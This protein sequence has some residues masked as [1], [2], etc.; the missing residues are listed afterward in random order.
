MRRLV[1]FASLVLSGLYGLGSAWADDDKAGLAFFESKIRPVL[2]K[3]CYE[4]HAKDAK[5]VGGKLLLDTRDDL[6]RGGESGS[7]MV[8]GKPGDSLLIHALRWQNDLEM[9]P[10]VPLTEA[11]IADFE[12][13]VAMGAPDP[14][15][16]E[17]AVPVAPHVPTETTH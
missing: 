1:P 16:P 12:K 7:P 9:P 2:V 3:Q 4:C 15:V 10:K 8:M 6:R 14:R 13:W 17:K 5:K 11:V